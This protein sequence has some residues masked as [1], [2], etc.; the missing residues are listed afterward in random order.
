MK[1]DLPQLIE[2]IETLRGAYIAF[3]EELRTSGEAYAQ[4]YYEQI[5]SDFGAFVERLRSNA[6]GK[7]LPEGWVPSSSHWLVREGRVLGVCNLRHALTENLLEFGGHVAYAVRLFE[8]G[9]GYATLM[10]SRVLELA[11]SGASGACS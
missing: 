9:R 3:V 4:G 5:E 10:L 7:D 11:A 8:L 1:G 2:P 6:E